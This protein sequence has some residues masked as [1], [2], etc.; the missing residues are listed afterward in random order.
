MCQSVNCKQLRSISAAAN[1][2][3]REWELEPLAINTALFLK[4]QQGETW[5][6]LALAQSG[7]ELVQLQVKIPE[8]KQLSFTMSLK[9]VQ[10]DNG[11]KTQALLYSQ[12]SSFK[13]ISTALPD[14][15]AELE[16][17]NAISANS[18]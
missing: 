3:K 2:A 4:G 12:I 13:L 5:R 9:H 7:Y 16:V 8:Q 6:F 18:L 14:H 11:I 1:T 10:S 15:L 17:I